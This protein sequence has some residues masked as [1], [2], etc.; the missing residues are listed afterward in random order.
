M[1]DRI[2]VFSI[3]LTPKISLRF[4]AFRLCR[5]TT[6]KIGSKREK[7]SPKTL[8]IP[9]VRLNFEFGSFFIYATILSFVVDFRDC[10]FNYSRYLLFPVVLRLCRKANKKTEVKSK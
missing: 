10:D 4:F 2:T 8:I 6:V 3:D 7:L 5:C 1:N 9:R